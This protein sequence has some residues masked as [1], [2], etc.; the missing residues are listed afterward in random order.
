[1]KVK[2]L[3]NGGFRGFDGVA[4]PVIVDARVEVGIFVS[5][6]ELL[7]I[8]CEAKYFT[9]GV[10]YCFIPGVHAVEVCDE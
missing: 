7:R 5:A 3:N 4:L 10:D 6:S 8:G 9:E 1:M 2:L